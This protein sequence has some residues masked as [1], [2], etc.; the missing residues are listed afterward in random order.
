MLFA[1]LAGAQTP[2]P[3]ATV[4]TYTPHMT[5]D[6]VSIH[7]SRGGTMSILQ[8]PP[9]ST[10]FHAELDTP[11]ALIVDA[12]DLESW[13]QLENLPE[14]AKTTRYD[15]TAKSDASADELLA[16]LSDK[17]SEAEQDHML[18]ELLKDRFKLRIHSEVRTSTIYE[19]V[20][21]QRTAKLMTPF[22]GDINQTLGS[23]SEVFSK[24]GLE[25]DSKGCPYF[26]F[27]SNLRQTLGATVVDHTGLSGNYAFHLMW[28]RSMV[29]EGEDAYPDIL[30]AIHE[31][32]GLEVKKTKGPTTIWVVD[33]IERPTAN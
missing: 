5:F 23:C 31:Q 28:A 29:P 3:V 2:A 15:V 11:F 32:L 6:V 19:L 30:T 27:L 13:S 25:I 24:T 4:S 21:T 14:W 26:I 20:S 12:Y 8:N 7:E 1:S 16:K 10:Y 33:H 18:Q 17:D 22:H 9:K